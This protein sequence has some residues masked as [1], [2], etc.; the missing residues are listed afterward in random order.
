[1]LAIQHPR[2]SLAERVVAQRDAKIST[3]PHKIRQKITNINST[4]FLISTVHLLEQNKRI[5]G[6]DSAKYTAPRG[7]RTHS[8]KITSRM[9]G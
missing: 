6:R 5:T 9:N 7:A 2:R 3:K 8:L 1:V 4:T